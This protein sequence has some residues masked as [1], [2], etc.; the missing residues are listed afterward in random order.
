VSGIGVIKTWSEE[1]ES[2]TGVRNWI[3]DLESGTG[4]RN[5]SWELEFMDPETGIWN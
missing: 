5:W 4:V 2:G 1:L 3:Q